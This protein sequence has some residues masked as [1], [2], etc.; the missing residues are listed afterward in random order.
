MEIRLRPAQ[1]KMARIACAF[2]VFL[3]SCDDDDDDDIVNYMGDDGDET[4]GDGDAKPDQQQMA[5]QGL[6]CC[7]SRHRRK[8]GN[9]LCIK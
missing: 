7:R 4:D 3:F 1:P 5:G 8:L 6:I 2:T 9:S